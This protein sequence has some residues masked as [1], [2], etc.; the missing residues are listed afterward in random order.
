MKR[1]IHIDRLV[2]RPAYDGD[3]GRVAQIMEYDISK[4][5]I[6]VPDPYTLT[7]A[8]GWLSS[9]RFERGRYVWAINRDGDVIGM[10][11][12]DPTLGYWIAKEHWGHGYVR[13]AA[14]AVLSAY[15]HD[16]FA[17]P[18]YSGYFVENERSARV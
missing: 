8:Q 10:I 9:L 13:E 14:H 17:D 16:P 3:A 15:F 4:W 12:L 5:L 11:G 18:I 7:D 2:L 6:P 1:I